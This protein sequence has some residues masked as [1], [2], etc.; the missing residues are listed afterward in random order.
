MVKRRKYDKE[1][2]QNIKNK[3]EKKKIYSRKNKNF[4]IAEF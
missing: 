4:R 1:F 3:K 2:V